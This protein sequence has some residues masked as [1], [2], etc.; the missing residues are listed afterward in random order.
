VFSE[1]RK[2]EGKMGGKAESGQILTEL[3]L[4]VGVLFALFYMLFQL[5]QT[6]IIEQKQQR[7]PETVNRRWRR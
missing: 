7:F 4:V 3:L 6:V 1:H 2:G 5:S